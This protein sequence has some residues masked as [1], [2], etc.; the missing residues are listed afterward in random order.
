M[1]DN[2]TLNKEVRELQ[3][4]LKKQEKLSS[5]GMLSAG[6]AHEIRNPLNFVLNF[7]GLSQN[8]LKDLQDTLAD[9]SGCLPEEKKED[10]EDILMTLSENLQKITEHGNRALNIIQGILLYSRGKEDEYIPTDTARLTKEYVWLSYHAMRANYK[11]FNLAIHESYEEGLPLVKL[12]PQDFSSVVLNVMNNACYAVWKKSQDNPGSSY[13]PAVR[14]DLRRENGWLVLT[15]EDN[16]EGMSEEVRQKLY[17]AFFTT[18]PVGQGTGLGMSIVKDIIE[19]K[20]RGHISFTSE[21]GKYTC[22]TIHIP[23]DV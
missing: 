8:L 1:K 19:N 7:S 14:I 5:L 3:E 10:T 15:I 16:G 2:E 13:Q 18:K 23:L 22:F 20:H 4:Q 12:I 9:M 17:E 21:A 11:G 6:I